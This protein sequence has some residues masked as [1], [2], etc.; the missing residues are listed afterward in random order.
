MGYQNA[1]EAI[2]MGNLKATDDKLPCGIAYRQGK[3]WV[4]YDLTTGPDNGDEAEFVCI[5]LGHQPTQVTE[6]G[7]AVWFSVIRSQLLT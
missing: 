1:I 2:R 7:A 5:G 4:L 6:N 3:G